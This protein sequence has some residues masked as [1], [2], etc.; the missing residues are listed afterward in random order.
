MLRVA[1]SSTT[2]RYI[3]FVAIAFLLA[4]ACLTPAA[5]AQ[6]TEA[7]R[8]IEAGHWKRARSIVEQRLK[9]APEDALNHFLLSQIRNAFGDHT[10]P[11]ML[12]EKAV[13]LDGNVAKYHRQVAE[14]LGVQA[15]HASAFQQVFLARRFH[16]EIETAL[17]LDARDVQALRDLVEFYL[18]APG[19]LGGDW[20]KAVATAER[21]AAIDPLEGLLSRAH[22]AAFT[23]Q[24]A[25]AEVLLQ[26]AA[27]AK[28]ASYRAQIELARFYLNS[29]PPKLEGAESAA[30][31]ALTLD[32]TRADS[33]SILAAVYAER[34]DWHA[35]DTVLME[36]SKEDPDDLAPYYRAADT[37]LKTGRE[38][39]RAEKYLRTYLGQEPEGNEPAAADAHWKLGSA[40][41]AMGRQSEAIAEWR[42][43]VR[44]DPNSPAARDLKRQHSSRAV[45]FETAPTLG[46]NQKAVI[47]VQC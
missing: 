25:E 22:I 5:F 47:R 14:V 42:E 39:A 26:Q 15:Q 32:P 12:A 34:S 18:L 3:A 9:Q 20:H 17:A 29:E 43:S 38:P 41:E 24:A 31:A 28:P 35:I 8:L 10:S 13:A 16:K 11:L 19:V 36:A 27:R 2:A 6:Q 1:S 44:L 37:L 7:E 33:Y 46:G 21:I 45:V 23:K 4:A 40:L 30:K